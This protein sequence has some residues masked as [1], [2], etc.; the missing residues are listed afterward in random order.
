MNRWH[1]ML[2]HLLGQPLP[3]LPALPGRMHV[4]KPDD[5]HDR[6][7]ESYSRAAAF[8]AAVAPGWRGW[9]P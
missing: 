3:E 6:Q 9:R 5:G 7:R 4:A 8:T 2:Q 1:L